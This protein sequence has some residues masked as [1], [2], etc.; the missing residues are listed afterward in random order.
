M[1][2]HIVLFKLKDNSGEEVKKAYHIL[3]NMEGNIPQLKCVEV[4]MDVVHSGRS[5]DVALITRFF[6]R[7][8]MEAYQVHPYHVS[9][10]LAKL[11]PILEASVTVDYEI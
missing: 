10:V 4:G 11:K 6:S 9:E 3:K 8:D 1:F 5:Y 7:G 2:V